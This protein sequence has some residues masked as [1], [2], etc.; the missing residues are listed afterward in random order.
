[1]C[2]VCKTITES[3]YLYI[4]ALQGITLG[5]LGVPL[6]FSLI[7]PLNEEEVMMAE[8]GGERKLFLDRLLLMLD[9][10]VLTL[11]VVGFHLLPDCWNPSAFLLAP[12]VCNA[13]VVSEISLLHPR[14]RFH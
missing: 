4:L 3:F 8:K 5:E 7:P 10:Y 11:D 9:R 6:E 13:M 14:L 1:M 12:L 2:F